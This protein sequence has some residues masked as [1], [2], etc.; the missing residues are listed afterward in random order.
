MTLALIADSVEELTGLYSMKVRYKSQ[1]TKSEYGEQNSDVDEGTED[2]LKV[3]DDL[4]LS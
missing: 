1:R 2:G 4:V 3:G